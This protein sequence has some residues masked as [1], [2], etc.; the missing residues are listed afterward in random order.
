V[1]TQLHRALTKDAKLLEHLTAAEAV[2]VGGGAITDSLKKAAADKHVKVVTTY[3][4]TEMCGGCVYNQKPLDGVEI[5][6]GSTGL[7]KLK[8]PMTA[9]N[10]LN[11]PELWQSLTADGWFQTSDIGEF[12]DGKLKV[13]GRADDVI[14]SGGEKISLI[15]IENLF[16]AH[17]PDQEVIAFGLP[18]AEWG[19]RLCLAVT[20]NLSLAQ[21][22][23][24]LIGVNSPKEIYIFK[25]IPKSVLGKVDRL[26]AIKLALG[27]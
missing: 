15:S 13:L 20:T 3:G 9:S 19:E 22:Q 25:Q 23:Q 24:K 10:Y 11:N 14:N 1:P 21:I 4:M 16:N 12:T 5:E 7:I 2:L 17:F 18:D 27:K 6:I 8:A 26:A